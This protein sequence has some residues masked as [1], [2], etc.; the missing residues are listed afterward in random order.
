MHLFLHGMKCICFV[1]TKAA[2]FYRFPVFVTCCI[3][4]FNFNIY[5]MTSSGL[6]HKLDLLPQCSFYTTGLWESRSCNA[7]NTTKIN[8]QQVISDM[9]T[10]R[11]EKHA[12]L[13]LLSH[14]YCHII[15]YESFLI[16]DSPSFSSLTIFDLLV[17]SCVNWKNHALPHSP[18]IAN[19]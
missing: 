12:W 18:H 5:F 14:F 13:H 6:F 10:C 1:Q 3:I 16:Y 9:T 8:K 11:L 7:I 19:I 4:S 17:I 2:S 15:T